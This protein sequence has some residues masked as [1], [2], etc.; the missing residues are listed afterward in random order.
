M[1][2][3]LSMALVFLARPVV[4]QLSLQT[5]QRSNQPSEV[6]V[7]FRDR[8]MEA[9]SRRKKGGGE[10]KISEYRRGNRQSCVKEVLEWLF[11]SSSSSSFKVALVNPLLVYIL[12]LANNPS[13][14]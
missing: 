2:Q 1:V 6:M 11:S 7:H 9:E 13:F 5:K 3:V 4:Q 8:A 14:S 12:K 10:T